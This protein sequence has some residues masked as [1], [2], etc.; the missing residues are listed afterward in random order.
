MKVCPC[1]ALAVLLS[2]CASPPPGNPANICSVFQEKDG[3]YASAKA[4]ARRWG[5]SVPLQL[6]I[7]NQESAF[8]DD[9]RPPRVRFWGVPLWRPSSAYG[10]GQAT[11]QTWDVYVR[12]T[13]NAGAD[14]DDFADAVD[15]VGWYTR[16]SMARLGVGRDDGYNHYLAY[17]EGPGGFQ[18]GTWRGKAWLQSAARKVAATASRYRRQLGACL[19]ELDSSN[20]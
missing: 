18:R 9:A 12:Q 16:Q 5:A 14:R 17:H 3:W 6:A 4:A 2:G 20:S 10:Y 1:L 7:I 13:G 8:V 11:D 15:F 19:A